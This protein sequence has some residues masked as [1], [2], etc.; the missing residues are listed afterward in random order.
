MW[1]FWLNDCGAAIPP[2]DDFRATVVFETAFDGGRAVG[3]RTAV[4]RPTKKYGLH[5]SRKWKLNFGNIYDTIIC[6]V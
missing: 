2:I 5:P 3:F 1:V 6:Y 4:S